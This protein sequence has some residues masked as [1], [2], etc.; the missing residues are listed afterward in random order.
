MLSNSGSDANGILEAADELLEAGYRIF[1]LGKSKRPATEGGFY[2]ST[3]DSAEV[4][5]WLEAGRLRSGLAIATGLPSSVV[6]IDADSPE[7][8]QWMYER[9]GGAHVVT[10][11][12]GHWYF[13]HPGDG[14][15]TSRGIY[16]VC[17]DLDCKGDGGYAAVPPSSGKRWTGT[18]PDRRALPKLPAEL[19]PT[20][21]EPADTSERRLD[22]ETFAP[23]VEMIANYYPALGQQYD[24]GRH[25]A[26][27]MQGNGLGEGDS[28]GLM[29]EAKKRQ[30]EGLDAEAERNIERV[31]TTTA[32]RLAAGEHVTGGPHVEEIAPGLIDKL[33]PLLGFVAPR[34]RGHTPPVREYEL[35]DTGNGER[36]ADEHGRN[37]RWVKK[38]GKFLVWTGRVWTIDEREEISRKAQVTAKGI[39]ADAARPEATADQQRKITRHAMASQNIQRL[40]GMVDAAKHRVAVSH[41]DFDSDPWLLNCQNGTVDLRTGGLREHK[42]ADMI[43][44]V[45]PVEYVPAVEAPVFHSF[46]ERII[47]S[48]EVRVYLQRAFGMALAGEIRDN[49]LVILYGTGSN[50][51]S[52]LMEAALKAFG[53]YGKA[54]APDLIMSKNRS[55]PTELADLFGARL[56]SCMESEEGRRL[57]EGLVKQLTGR[58]RISARRM[59]EDLWEFDPTHT[60][61]LGTNHKPEIRGMDHAIWRRLK[62]VPFLVKIPDAEQDK[63]LPDKLEAELPGILRWVV[64]G[65]LAWQREGLNEPVEVRDATDEYRSDM[66]LLQ[67]FIEDCCIVDPDAEAPA[68]PLHQQ[69]VEWCHDVGEKQPL[70][71]RAFGGRLRDRGYESF[72][73]KSGAYK[74]LAGW[75]GL[76]LRSGGYDPDIGGPGGGIRVKSPSYTPLSGSERRNDSQSSAPESRI[77]MP[78]SPGSNIRSGGSGPNSDINELVNPREEN[79]SENSSASSAEAGEEAEFGG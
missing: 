47:P 56:V 6:V 26:G 72:K 78:K 22:P 39:H 57:N 28:Y 67:Q 65:C 5:E 50:G 40:R 18:I 52:T 69:Y 20:K 63:S 17:P 58:D 11:R 33:G 79:Y 12:G 2:A 71:Q 38:W 24:F 37:I 9:H 42:R 1:P 54:G 25:L 51:K 70:K 55:H 73:F 7:A 60:L 16:E 61:F 13:R 29:L 43:T 31:V 19:R 46:L 76:G 35:T 75:R 64:E 41:E 66:D 45:T 32:Q 21:T 68:T 62:L 77:G 14:R 3:D 44:K 10:A 30:P 8:F 49:V 59:R 36:F 23:A 15:V 34:F 53:D 48:A 27:Y 4:R 74:D